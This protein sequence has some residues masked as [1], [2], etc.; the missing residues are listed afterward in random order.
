[1]SE[2]LH[3]IQELGDS[4]WLKRKEASKRLKELAQTNPDILDELDKLLDTDNDDIVFWT[5]QTVGAIPGKKIIEILEKTANKSK[6]IKSYVALSLGE[7]PEEESVDILLSYMDDNSWNVCNNAMNSIVKKGDDAIEKIIE[8]LKKANYNSAYWLT[9]AL[10]KM[11]D[12]GIAV[13]EHF[14]KF[15]NKDVSI[16]VTEAL[17]ES[18]NK[19][20]IEVLLKCLIDESH[21]VRQNAVD[22][23]IKV[24]PAVIEPM[25]L[26]LN[27]APMH[28]KS[29]VEKVIESLDSRK[30][31]IM[32]N[33]LES[34]NRN[35]KMLSA[36][37][38]GKTKSNF[39]IEPLIKVLKDK[40]WLVR[41]SAA[42][43]LVNIGESCIPNL[44][45]NLETDDE[46][47][48]YWIATVLGKIGEPAL[49]ELIRILRESSKDLRMYAVMALGEFRDEKAIFPLINA[50]ADE[51]WPVRNSA[52]NALKNFGSMALVPILK[53][54][55]SQN[56]DI[57]FWA[58]KVFE[59]IAPKD[60]PL[61]VELLTYSNDGELRYLVAYG[62]SIIKCTEAIPA[63]IN[64]LLND[65]NDWVRKYAATALGKIG[66]EKAIDPLIRVLGD[67]N[68]EIA[69]W[70]AKV[71]GQMG[72]LAVEKLKDTL[73]H[74]EEKVRFF[75]I[76]A[77][78][79]IGDEKSIEILIKILGEEDES[80][81]RAVKALAETEKSIPSLI[82]ALGNSNL[83]IRSNASKALVK[84]GD[85]A[86]E[87]LMEVVNSDN[88]EVHYWA[89]KTIR[90]IQ[91]KVKI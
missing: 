41:K 24:G 29:E 75:A 5:I 9:K 55:L 81:S 12:K 72:D 40:L 26:F 14:L 87:P 50:L 34:E 84:I 30:I 62:V 21:N 10:S 63:L 59:E 91:T 64:A 52:A 25:L 78:G 45:K 46:N 17:G 3:L 57:R 76:I 56:D 6:T 90:E 88:K 82:N 66:D 73:N 80:A 48:K 11:G 77:L 51:A 86:L 68:E 67:H 44:V 74:P 58:R 7:N 43:G 39:A 4:S 79:S 18:S 70:V 83:N 69:Y 19:K 8:S 35:L 54:L 32:V 16:L 85:S 33:L 71:L 37:F 23:L 89:T 22:A 1:M 31:T 53:S 61:L 13:L 2:Y 60:I 27:N 49:P 65:N 20:A 36:E 15:N 47:T 38:L 42:K 28:V